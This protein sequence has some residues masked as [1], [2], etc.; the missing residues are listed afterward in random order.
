MNL[1]KKNASR[2]HCLLWWL[3]RSQRLNCDSISENVQQQFR[4]RETSMWPGIRSGQSCNQ[5]IPSFLNTQSQNMWVLVVWKYCSKSINFFHFMLFC[6][7]HQKS[8]IIL[9]GNWNQ[10][11]TQ[12]SPN[13]WSDST[14][15]EAMI[16]FWKHD[17]N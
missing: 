8:K 6:F 17:W 11:S 12:H 15:A 13:I 14:R 1:C 2:V 4:R 9:R 5:C 3:E 7:P 16:E 10:C